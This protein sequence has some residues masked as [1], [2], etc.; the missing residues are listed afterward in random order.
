M[1]TGIRKKDT[2]I[3]VFGTLALAL[4]GLVVYVWKQTA[5]LKNACFFITGGTVNSVSSSNVNITLFA[6]VKNISDITVTLT[7]M[8]LDIYVNDLYITHISSTVNQ[9]IISQSYTTLSLPI[10]FNPDDLLKAG[11]AT[12]SDIIDNQ[13]SVIIKTSGIASI[14][15]GGVNV[16]NYQVNDEISLQ[17]IE[18]KDE[19][20]EPC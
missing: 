1:L 19:V 6:K 20:K 10:S 7:G 14:S 5:K 12:V 17:Q 2:E 4:I 16:D 11:A 8:E 13:A 18:S 9:D 15:A 3:I